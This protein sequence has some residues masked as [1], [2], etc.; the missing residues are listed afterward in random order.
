M[1]AASIIRHVRAAAARFGEANQGNIAVIFAIALL[2]VLSFVGAAID[3]SRVNAARSSMQAALNSTALML[4]KDLSS[5]IITAAQIN[6]KAQA[7]FNALYTN[8]DA[9]SVLV[10]ATYAAAT[11]TGSNIVVSGAGSI[12]T[13]FMKVAGFPTLSFS[14]SST[15]AWGNVKM[16]VAL[17][18]DN[19]GSMSQ[20]GKIAALRTAVAGSGGLID[21]LSGLAQNPGDV[22]ISVIPFAKV[23]NAG[24]G[25]YDASWI[26]WTDWLNPPTSQPNNGS[27]EAT[28]P[29]NWHAVGP[30]SVCPFTNNNGGFV[31]T[32]GPA[33]GSSK[34]TV[35]GRNVIPSSGTYSGYIC[36]GVDYNSHT[37]YNGCWDS[38]ATSPA[39]GVFCS[40][41]NN[42]SCPT[43][44]SGNTVSGCNC[45]GSGTTRS[46]TGLTYTH[47]WT[48]PSSTDTTDNLNQPRVSAPVGFVNNTWTPTN[49]TPTVAN[50]WTQTSTNPIST[51]TGC[52]TDRTQSF[53][54]TGDAPNQVNIDTLFPA[55]QEG[56]GYCNPRSN[57]TLEP[58]MPM[59]YNWSTLK[60][61]VN[62]MQPTGSTD[63]SVGLAWAWQSLLQTGPIPAP[64]EDPNTTYN[65]VI[66]ILSDGL[67]TED[68]WPDY[69]NGG[70]ENGTDIDNRQAQQCANIK[71]AT[72][73][74]GR[75]MYTIY[76]IQVDTSSPPDPV[77]T[78]L[79]NC[80]SDSTKFFKLTN[81]NQIAT[82][83]TTIG[84]ALSQLR[85]A[86]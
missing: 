61:A 5:G 68:R 54:E 52:I 26:D 80:A 86:Q 27:T 10:S 73:A 15:T 8:K 49:S 82:T 11:G 40:G 67:N 66:I 83:F 20:N 46:C 84:T 69:G 31:C 53:D 13:D 9:Q 60:T 35:S 65:R 38:V 72:D 19:T 64:A 2:P 24:A 1:L 76:T 71:A 81:S 33:N 6:T 44:S 30:G 74:N 18:L 58:V 28:L 3:Y 34:S 51:W 16:R 63:Q 47:H 59:T 14:S 36:P 75:P 23:V 62:A 85:V 29:M 37:F 48:Q 22:Y 55:N 25:N 21:Q 70:T 57:P 56:T 41:S 17:A 32:T 7:Y 79:E 42:C 50:V 77:S 43:N 39:S 45:T 4:S 12:T 78:V